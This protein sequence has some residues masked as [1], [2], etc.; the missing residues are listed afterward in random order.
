MLAKWKAYNKHSSTDASSISCST[1][2]SSVTS[3][4]KSSK[5]YAPPPPSPS[6][7]GIG[8]EGSVLNLS[9]SSMNHRFE[10]AMDQHNFPP[11]PFHHR[12]CGSRPPSIVLVPSNLSS[13]SQDESSMDE[14]HSAVYSYFSSGSHGSRRKVSIPSDSPS[15]A[16]FQQVLLLAQED[17]EK[18][19]SP[20]H[21]FVRKNIE[22]FTATAQS[23]SEPAPGR[24]NKIRIGHVGL[25]C[26]HC[27]IQPPSQRVKRAV[28]YPSSIA[29]IYSQV[30]DMKVDH[31]EKCKFMPVHL[32]E[33]FRKL[34]LNKK[35][36][37]K[38]K[39]LSSEKGLNNSMSRYYLEST[40]KMGME[41]SADGGVRIRDCNDAT[42]KH[43][44]QT[45][46]K[47]TNMKRKMVSKFSRH[48]L[49]QNFFLFIHEIFV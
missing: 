29:R 9:L 35:S 16:N 30:S 45:Q 21:C 24:K 34:K 33:T 13:S 25:R 20:I 10:M 41:D 2:S 15:V 14:E 37:R 47:Q 32:K 8:G 42:M 38:G 12:R 7:T 22:V 11:P 23:I 1:S 49:H 17:D 40:V 28:V 39:S 18:Y 5:C 48:P 3:Q 44:S 31:F 43:I 36:E 27:G 4:S 46:C 6:G 19:L 26:V